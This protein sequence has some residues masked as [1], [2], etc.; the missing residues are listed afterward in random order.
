M[1]KIDSNN[2]RR[3]HDMP[4]YSEDTHKSK[5]WEYIHVPSCAASIRSE[6]KKLRKIKKYGS[7]GDW[8]HDLQVTSPLLYPLDHGV[9]MRNNVVLHPINPIYVVLLPSISKPAC[10]AVQTWKIEVRFFL[11][12]KDFRSLCSRRPCYGSLLAPWNTKTFCIFVILA[13]RRQIWLD[14]RI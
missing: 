5:I 14:L 10:S 2:A 13:S 3:R 12:E 1:V 4:T 7:A 6:W 8:T 11:P 9:K